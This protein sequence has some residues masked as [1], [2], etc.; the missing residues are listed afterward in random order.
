MIHACPNDC[1]LYIKDFK[2]LKSC[3]RCELL[4]YKL[5]QKEKL[6]NCL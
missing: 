6:L 1:I 2:L 3:P 4:R 5:K